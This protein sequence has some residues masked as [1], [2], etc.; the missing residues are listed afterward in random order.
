MAK[1]IIMQEEKNN[2]THENVME[3]LVEEE[4]EKQL[5]GYPKNLREYINKVEVSTYALNRLPPLYASSQKGKMQQKQI[6]AKKYHQE[7]TIAVRRALAAVER[8]PIRQSTPILTETDL[9]M[10]EVEI[11]LEELQELL[12]KRQLLPENNSVLSWDNLVTVIQQAINKA[13][14]LG[15][16]QD[17]SPPD[18]SNFTPSQ[19]LPS[20][21][22]EDITDNE[23]SN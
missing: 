6:G 9:K 3:L 16:L 21:F 17:T 8:D 7:I 19:E 12:E 1:T 14:W 5:K 13:T 20:N 18:N 4:I 11:A 10:K 15:N 2:Q 22:H 23:N